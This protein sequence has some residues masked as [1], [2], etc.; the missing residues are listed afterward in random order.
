MAQTTSFFL[1]KVIESEKT[2][3]ISLKVP[4]PHK[5]KLTQNSRKQIKDFNLSP[6]F[7]SII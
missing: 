6:I 4:R 3:G 7:F 1:K 5:S 2:E